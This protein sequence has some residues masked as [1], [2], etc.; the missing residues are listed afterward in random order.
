[1]SSKKGTYVKI[2][3]KITDWEWYKNPATCRLYE[4]LIYKANYEDNKT[5]NILVKS[6]QRMTSLDSLVHETGLSRQQIRT[7]L[8]NLESTHDITQQVT[9]HY[10]IITICNYETYQLE[11]DS[12]NTSINTPTNRQS[13]HQ[14]TPIKE[15]KKDKNN[16]ILQKHEAF[17]EKF[18]EALE[19]NDKVIKSIN[20]KS[21]SW[22]KPIQL[23]ETQDKI[24]WETIKLA[25]GYYFENIDSLYMPE[26]RSTGAFRKKFDKLVSHYE[27]ARNG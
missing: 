3:R 20:P 13:T 12:S 18:Y 23:L 7:A 25:A 4:H 17:A 11:K 14:L 26:I 16:K 6:G 27:R 8:S 21:R 2:Y 24:E 1:M 19:R 15:V 9:H 5:R 22:I 10:R